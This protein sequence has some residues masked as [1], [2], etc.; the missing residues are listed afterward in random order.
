MNGMIWQTRFPFAYLR[1]SKRRKSCNYRKKIYFRSTVKWE[2]DK[3]VLMAARNI[4]INTDLTGKK[5][6]RWR[7]ES[8]PQ[9]FQRQNHISWGS[10]IHSI[11]CEKLQNRIF[12]IKSE[13]SAITF[14]LFL[15]FSART[16]NKIKIQ[17]FF[18][19]LQKKCFLCIS[20]IGLP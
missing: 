11:T 2:Y 14:L 15:Q 9:T 1:R 19:N 3:K 10:F 7:Q 17:I 6:G 18:S 12:S 8:N 20:G 16:S 5:A 4:F 13:A